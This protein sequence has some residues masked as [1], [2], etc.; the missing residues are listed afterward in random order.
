MRRRCH[1]PNDI[2]NVD[3]H[4]HTQ[5]TQTASGAV[6]YNKLPKKYVSVIP[7]TQVRNGISNEI[8]LLEMPFV[9]LFLKRRMWN[10]RKV[11]DKV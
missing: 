5:I 2:D 1:I 9:F 6:N 7:L 4:S 3:R 11:F 8:F 10:D